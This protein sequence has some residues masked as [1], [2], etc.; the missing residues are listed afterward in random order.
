MNDKYIKVADYPNL[1]RDSVTGAIINT[2]QTKIKKAIAARNAAIAEK[3]K[4]NETCKRLDDIQ[5]NLDNTHHNLRNVINHVDNIDQTLERLGSRLESLQNKFDN[6]NQNLDLI[7][8]A[9]KSK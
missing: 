3:A 6:I 2:N 7:V 1:V 8:K 5:S 4:I 9:L